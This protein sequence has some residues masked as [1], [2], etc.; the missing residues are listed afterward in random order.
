MPKACLSRAAVSSAKSW[1]IPA[2]LGEDFVFEVRPALA[3]ERAGGNID[4]VKSLVRGEV[5]KEVLA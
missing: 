1:L 3:R 5:V 4:A 2:M